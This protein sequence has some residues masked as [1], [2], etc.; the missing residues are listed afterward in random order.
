MPVYELC[1]RILEGP[2]IQSFRGMHTIREKTME[3]LKIVMD[4]AQSGALVG[5]ARWRDVEC[6]GGHGGID[7]AAEFASL[8]IG[9]HVVQR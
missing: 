2:L 7:L 6:C 5:D 1:P 4:A 3:A 8:K 9:D